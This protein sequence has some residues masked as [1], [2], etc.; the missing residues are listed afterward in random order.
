MSHPPKVSRSFHF[1]TLLPIM[2]YFSH[3]RNFSHQFNDVPPDFFGVVVVFNRLCFENK[4]PGSKPTKARFFQTTS[5]FLGT[6]ARK[7][8][9]AAE[10]FVFDFLNLFLLFAFE[11]WKFSNNIEYCGLSL[12]FRP[13]NFKILERI[14]KLYY[15]IVAKKKKTIMIH[16]QLHIFTH[17]VH[18]VCEITPQL[19]NEQF[20]GT[21][22]KSS[23][24]IK[25]IFWT[26]VFNL[27]VTEMQKS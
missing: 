5:T 12:T 7:F 9:L 20:A 13:I 18:C 17:F 24:F 27:I 22:I 4:G 2:H 3:T 6:S 1:C 10:G 21:P 11:F 8:F 19:R 16:S 23:F 26:L 14:I 25:S 15:K